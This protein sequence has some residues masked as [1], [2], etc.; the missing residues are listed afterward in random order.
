M[1]TYKEVVKVEKVVSEVLCNCCGKSAVV[2][3]SSCNHHR[4][5]QCR[6]SA[7]VHGSF[8][9]QHSVSIEYDICQNCFEH[10]IAPLMTA[11][12]PNKE[13]YDCDSGVTTITP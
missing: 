8:P 9:G 13:F 2:D 5:W 12:P 7:V 11:F 1:K 10:K 3:E 6:I 4:S